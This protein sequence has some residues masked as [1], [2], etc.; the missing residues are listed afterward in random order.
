MQPK[1][2]N[3]AVELVDRDALNRARFPACPIPEQRFQRWCRSG[4]LAGAVKIGKV[5]MV[6]LPTFDAAVV[7]ALDSSPV[8]TDLAAMVREAR[9][10]HEQATQ[11]G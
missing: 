1:T 7:A 6:N 5:W 2:S 3:H 10:K 11:D 8:Q 4:E 9:K